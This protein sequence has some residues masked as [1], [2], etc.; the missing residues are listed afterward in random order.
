MYTRSD[1][2]ILP[3]RRR[4]G[5]RR[6]RAGATRPPRR[7]DA[8]RTMAVDVGAGEGRQSAGSVGTAARLRPAATGCVATPGERRPVPDTVLTPVELVRGA[9]PVATP[10]EPVA[11]ADVP[12]DTPRGRPDGRSRT[13]LAEVL[14]TLGA[15]LGVAVTGLTVF[16]A[17]SGLRP[18]VVRSGSMEP[19]IPTGSMVL[20]QRIGVEDIRVGDVVA[21]ERPDHTRV[22]HRV[23]G[24]EAKGATAELILKGDANEDPDP[25]PVAVTRADRLVAQVP[26][27]GRVAA[28]LATARGGFL[29]G[30]LFTAVA[31]HVLRRHPPRRRPVPAHA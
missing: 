12:S 8:A 18:L 23:I 24:I 9:H 30:C 19:T 13:V 14:L 16:A 11:V 3:A 6:V 10:I 21:V 25:V 27:I 1:D 26:E 7:G 17:Q 4:R 20:M 5:L 22:T 28:W 31:M 15:V 29:V 2:D